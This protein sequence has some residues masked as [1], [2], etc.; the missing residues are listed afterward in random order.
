MLVYFLTKQ[1]DV[2]NKIGDGLLESGHVS[3]IF[4][5]I[6]EL[7]AGLKMNGEKKVDLIAADYRIIHHDLFDFYDMLIDYNCIVP[8]IFY[9]D[10]YPDAGQR[11]NYWKIQNQ[12]KYKKKIQTAQIERT[13]PVME[14][15]NSLIE[16][17]EINPFITIVNRPCKSTARRK[18]DQSVQFDIDSFKIKHH[19]QNS[20]Y[21]VFRFLYDNRGKPVNARMLC[22]YLWKSYTPQKKHTLYAYIHDLRSAMRQETE[23]IIG[24][25]RDYKEMYRLTIEIPSVGCNKQKP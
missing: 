19:I 20:R 18:S 15:I 2:C 10:P 17:Q 5:S 7:Y 9:N 21:K 3:V 16:S 14:R 23:F 8:F 11:V 6:E 24:I 25:K 13:A 12:L 22:E 4:K 1:P